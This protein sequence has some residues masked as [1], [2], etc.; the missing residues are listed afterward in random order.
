MN[1]SQLNQCKS[2]ILSKPCPPEEDKFEGKLDP[3]AY[4]C[5][6]NEVPPEVGDCPKWMPKDGEEQ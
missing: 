5:L 6:I 1:E 2:C 3:T 4:E